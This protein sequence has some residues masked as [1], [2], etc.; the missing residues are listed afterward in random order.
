MSLTVLRVVTSSAMFILL[1]LWH[2]AP[3]VFNASVAAPLRPRIHLPQGPPARPPRTLPFPCGAPIFLHRGAFP[4]HHVRS[5]SA[6]WNPTTLPLPDRPPRAVPIQAPPDFYL[7]YTLTR[8]SYSPFFLV[9]VRALLRRR[10]PKPSRSL[11]RP[12]EACPNFGFMNRITARGAD[13]LIV[14]VFDDSLSSR[15]SISIAL[16]FS[17]S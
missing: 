11:H 10:R 15:G 8:S 16:P 1:L 9:F 6:P 17:R 2:V 14:G 12:L 13:F 5:R 7:T 4:P 3:K